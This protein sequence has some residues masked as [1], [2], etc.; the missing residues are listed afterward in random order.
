MPKV[1]ENAVALI[2]GA[3]DDTGASVARAFAKEGYIACLV[4]RPSSVLDLEKLA[5][6]IEESGG[7]AFPMPTD[8]RDEDSMV[9]LSLWAVKPRK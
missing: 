3:G 5:A 7:R 2:I 9:N 6:E 1:H 4:R 8:A